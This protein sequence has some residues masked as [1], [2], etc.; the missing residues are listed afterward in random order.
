[1]NCDCCHEPLSTENGWLELC[2]EDDDGVLCGPHTN[3]MPTTVFCHT[4]CGPDTGYAIRL[5][6]IHDMDWITQVS[7]KPWVNGVF[8]LAIMTAIA[9]F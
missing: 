7:M 2:S 9:T 3:G 6:R 4:D 5:S 1:M 8:I